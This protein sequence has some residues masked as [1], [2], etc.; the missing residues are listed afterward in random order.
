MNNSQMK[1]AIR[2]ALNAVKP[3]LKTISPHIPNYDHLVEG[4]KQL[5]ILRQNPQML[6]SA[7]D[8]IKIIHKPGVIYDAYWLKICERATEKALEEIIA[9]RV[10]LNEKPIEDADIKRL[11]EQ[12][13]SLGGKVSGAAAPPLIYKDEVI[14]FSE[15]GSNGTLFEW[16]VAAQVMRAINE[17]PMIKENIAEV[18]LQCKTKSKSTPAAKHDAEFDL[19]ITTRF[20][21]LIILEVKTYDFSGDTAKGKDHSA[22]RKSGTYGR[23]IMV[24]PIIKRFIGKDAAGNEEYPCFIDGKIRAQKKTAEQNNISYSY[25]DEIQQLLEKELAVCGRKNEG[26]Y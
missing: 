4:I 14:K 21:T 25:L 5:S 23:A 6:N 12:L 3:E 16:M 17:N 11:Q 1:D 15:L 10:K 7:L 18:H 20:G 24:G 19:V 2:K 26:S 8:R 13:E 22:Y 9:D